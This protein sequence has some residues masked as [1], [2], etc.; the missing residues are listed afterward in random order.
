MTA[1][2]RV[3]PGIRPPSSKV[4]GP[5]ISI[6]GVSWPVN[7]APTARIPIVVART[8][9]NAMP[10]P[11]LAAV[12]WAVVVLL[13]SEGSPAE[14]VARQRLAPCDPLRDIPWDR[15]PV[16]RRRRGRPPRATPHWP[17]RSSH[18]SG[19]PRVRTSPEP[20]ARAGGTAYLD[21][22]SHAPIAPRR[23]G[24]RPG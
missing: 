23:A 4:A 10:S 20:R 8:A 2:W 5:L 19:P 15:G 16:G 3:S 6:A 24:G 17:V 18:G 12:P 1:A 13:T 14:A 22:R 21:D 9:A 11:S 7:A